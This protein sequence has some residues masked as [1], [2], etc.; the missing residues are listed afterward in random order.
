M[1]TNLC[2]G[3]H[4]DEKSTDFDKLLELKLNSSGCLNSIF[5]EPSYARN[6]PNLIIDAKSRSD[7]VTRSLTD[8]DGF[9]LIII[10]SINYAKKST[11]LRKEIVR[12]GN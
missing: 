6:R 1:A 12:D 5:H 2:V 9:E 7:L 11:K 4:P 3:T 10:E 8:G